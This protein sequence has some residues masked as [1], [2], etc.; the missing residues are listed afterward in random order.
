[1]AAGVVVLVVLPRVDSVAAVVASSGPLQCRSSDIR[2]SDPGRGVLVVLGQ[3]VQRSE[4][5]LVRP[6]DLP[7]SCLEVHS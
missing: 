7:R 5:G 3:W 1:M 2:V 6:P 4:C